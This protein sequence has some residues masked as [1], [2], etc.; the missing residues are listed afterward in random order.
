MGIDMHSKDD[1]PIDNLMDE[2]SQEQPK[3]VP[4][5]HSP[6]PPPKK[7]PQPPDLGTASSINRD[8][9]ET[10]KSGLLPLAIAALC[11][12]AVGL[13][14]GLGVASIGGKSL[15]DDDR[16]E[17]DAARSPA[18]ANPYAEAEA[19]ADAYLEDMGRTMGRTLDL[20]ALDPGERIMRLSEEGFIVAEMEGLRNKER[21][22]P[23][24]KPREAWGEIRV[25]T[26]W[27]RNG[28]TAECDR[29]GRLIR[30]T[31]YIEGE[32]IRSEP[33]EIF[34]SRNA[35]SPREHLAA[36]AEFLASS[37]IQ[38]GDPTTKM[39]QYQ[40]RGR[41]A[42]R[43]VVAGQGYAA[44]TFSSFQKKIKTG[45]EA[46]Q[47][48]RKRLRLDRVS[49][50]EKLAESPEDFNAAKIAFQLAGSDATRGR[51]ILDQILQI[52]VLTGTSAEE[53]AG[54][55]FSVA[56]LPCVNGLDNVADYGVPAILG[57]MKEGASMTDAA[58]LW[59][60]AVYS[61]SA[62]NP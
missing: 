16:Q 55:F 14:L 58:A 15:A 10:K 2:W 61:M 47:Y 1:D 19:A 12:L 24:G 22:W 13:L 51:R 34:Q 39:E 27:L 42:I 29:N 25:G 46:R 59:A 4:A 56:Y 54:F 6:P 38:C 50:G 41:A 44:R 5:H 26:K 62:S 48:Y 17:R 21:N 52:Q 7:P 3:H 32:A 45:E 60:T 31:W 53:V 35:V 36:A 37:P 9:A 57:C 28:V 23:D 8:A 18:G 30:T 40:A 20:E 33:A 49:D 11:G 43:E